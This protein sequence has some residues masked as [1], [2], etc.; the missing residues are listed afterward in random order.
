MQGLIDEAQ[1]IAMNSRVKLD[2]VQEV[3]VAADFL[4]EN[5]G[6]NVVAKSSTA[7]ERF[8]RNTRQHIALVAVSLLA[9]ILVAVP[10]GIAA[11]RWRRLG[12]VIL[13][14]VGLILE[15]AV[16]A[17]GL[18]IVVQLLFEWTELTIV[19]RGQRVSTRF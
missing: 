7:M 15:G 4:S 17:A 1:M 8:W 2:G 10:L 3:L 11:A 19:P 16:P 9:A 14:D 12:H 18:A 5:L 6:I 13:D